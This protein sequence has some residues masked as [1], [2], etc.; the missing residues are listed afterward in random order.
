MIKVL[1]IDASTKSTGISVFQD[2]KLV[3]YECVTISSNEDTLDRIL[4]M[5]KKV[6]QVYEKYKPNNIIMEEVLP[7]DV[8][9]NQQ[10]YKALIYLQAAIVLQLHKSGGN[11]QFYTASHWRA[12]VGIKTGRG[13]KR[14]H[15]KE[16]SQYLIRQKYNIQVNDDISDAI[17]LGLAYI[18]QNKG[19]F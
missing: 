2:Y 15:L 5:A 6:R 7:Q 10:V 18:K 4:K 17:C 9:H 13:I 1:A 16:A 3:Y 8:K 14:Q 12:A 11:V 19:A